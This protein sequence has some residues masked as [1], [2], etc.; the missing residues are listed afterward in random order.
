MGKYDQDEEIVLGQ[1][2]QKNWVTVQ[3]RLRILRVKD[4]LSFSLSGPKFRS[5]R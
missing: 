2:V 3:K 4:I 1:Y 5:K